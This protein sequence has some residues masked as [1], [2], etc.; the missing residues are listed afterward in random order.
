MQTDQLTTDQKGALAEAAIAYAAIELG[1]GVFRPLCDG[2]R[3]DLI[4]DLGGR[5][6]RVQCKTAVFRGEVLAVPWYSARRSS[7]GF[8]KHL[9]T[10]D[11]IDAVAAYSP[12]LRRC[13]LLPSDRFGRRTYVQLRLA[14]PKNN[15]RLGINWADD[16]A[17]DVTL[18]S[19][20]G[21]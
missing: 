14:P 6:L 13:F 11:E 10:P 15:Q 12:D 1:I 19:L 7:E 17:F 20:L 18:R 21:P 8:V 5:L 16:C 3:Y 2:A 4:F 9:Y